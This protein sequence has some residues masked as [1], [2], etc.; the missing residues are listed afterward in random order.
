VSSAANTMREPE[1]TGVPSLWQ[2]PP[3]YIFIKSYIAFVI[4][5]TL[6]VIFTFI[7]L[8]Q[9]GWEVNPLAAV[10]LD[11]W[12]ERAV[13]GLSIYKYALVLFV[14]IICENVGRRCYRTGRTLAIFA[15]LITCVPVIAAIVQ[16]AVVDLT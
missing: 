1:G 4:V 12:G 9:G 16:L 7:V 11:D 13:L 14:V 5:S 2:W 15:V 3:R 8:S 6:D 10:I